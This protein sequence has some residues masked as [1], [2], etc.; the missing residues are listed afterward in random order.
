MKEYTAGGIGMSIYTIIAGVNGTGK[1]SLRGV[2]EGQNLNLGHIIDPDLIAK[3][4]NN[5]LIKAAKIAV[6]KIRDCLNKNISFTQETTLS[7]R[8]VLTTIKQA[9]KQGYYVTL[10]YIG[11][12]SA[13]ES[14]IRIANRVRK[15]GHNIPEKDV[16][17]RYNKRF[18]TLIDVISY[19]DEIIFYDN[20]N[21]FVKVA[22]IK[23]GQF[24]Y[25]NG[26]RPEWI[27]EL[28]NMLN[29]Y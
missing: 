9:R 11:L 8:T 5:D 14:L 29:D 16:R 22:E 10:Y 23:N 25:I 21:G 3:E 6:A 1:S 2:L 28:N 4:N 20:E 19:C 7:G 12:S 18:D 24:R 15:G 17:K 13:E 26:Y 27:V